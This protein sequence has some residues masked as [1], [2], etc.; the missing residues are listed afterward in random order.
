MRDVM[1]VRDLIVVLGFVAVCL[2]GSVLSARGAFAS[3]ETLL[4]LSKV[5]G[6]DNPVLARA[7]CWIGL[8]GCTAA[9]VARLLL[10]AIGT[11]AFWRLLGG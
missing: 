3:R 6:T 5:I 8:L 11:P 2:G 7:V 4:S 9:G 10:F 1:A